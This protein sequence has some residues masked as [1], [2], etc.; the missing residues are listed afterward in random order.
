GPAQSFPKHVES[1]GIREFSGEPSTILTPRGCADWADGERSGSCA[2]TAAGWCDGRRRDGRRRCRRSVDRSASAALVAKSRTERA[3]P[4]R[5]RQEIQI[6]LRP[7]CLTSKVLAF[8]IGDLF[9]SRN[10]SDCSCKQFIRDESSWC[11]S[12]QHC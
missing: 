5:E 10:P 3:V 1:A 12:L 4:V 7:H 6:L 2:S 9:Y 11:C 8:E